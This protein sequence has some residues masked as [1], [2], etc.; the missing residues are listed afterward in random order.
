MSYVL[1]L[2]E[3]DAH[4]ARAGN[5]RNKMTPNKTESEISVAISARILALVASGSSIRAAIDQVLG[6]GTSSQVIGD[7]YDA[8]RA[9]RS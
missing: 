8:L 3:H 1:Y 5:W 4:P 7:V 2:S 6:D 9:G